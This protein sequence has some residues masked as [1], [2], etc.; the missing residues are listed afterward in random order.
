MMP[1]PDWATLDR[2]L[3][4][5]LDLEGPERETF[6]AS[7][8]DATREALVP[9]LR[10]A[11]SEDSL[12]DHPGVVLSSLR[13]NTG[14]PDNGRVIEG[15]RI[16]PYQIEALVGEG[17]MGRVFCAH[18]VDGAFDQTVAVKV[19]RS[20]LTLAGSDVAT[21]LRRERDVL[22]SLDHPGISRLLDGGET[23][24]GVPYLVTEF[25]DGAPITTWA[26]EH[27]LDV[28]ARI[29]LMI[30]VVQ[31]VDHAHRRFVVHRDLKPSNVLVTERDGVARPV[32]LDFGIA[33]LLDTTDNENSNGAPLT[34][35]GLRVL[36]PAYAAPELFDPMATVTTASDVYGLG[37]L[38]YELLTGRRPHNDTSTQIGPPTREPT[39]PSKVITTGIKGTTP[40]PDIAVRSRTLRGDLDTICLKALH[41]E[42]TRRYAS[43]SDFAA[44]LT[45]YLEGRPIEARTDS[46]AYVAGRFIRRHRAFVAAATLALVALIGG[47]GISLVLLD[48]ERTA[49]AETEAAR[50]HATEAANLLAELF[51]SASPTPDGQPVTVREVLE[52]GMERI[53]AIESDSLRAYLL[54]VTGVTYI[55][56]SFPARADSMLAASL[57]LYG[58]EASGATVSGFRLSYAATRDA[59]GDYET[60]LALGSRVYEDWKASEATSSLV[61]R[62]LAILSRAYR[63]LGQPDEALHY[64]EQAVLLA[65]EYDHRDRLPWALLELGDVLAALERYDEAIQTHR[66][67]VRAYEEVYGPE[68]D[69]TYFSRFRLGVA[70]ADV[71]RYDEA[72]TL[73]L[74]VE[75]YQTRVL[76][77]T[78]RLSYTLAHIGGFKLRQGQYE[79]AATYYESALTMGRPLLPP[80]H[81]DLDRWLS[82]LDDVRSRSSLDR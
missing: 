43:A 28:T 48:N 2:A 70:L 53:N 78:V 42:P 3:D 45:R 49:L 6:L 58:D 51:Q 36:T 16:G 39:R 8:D 59:F 44:D 35:T 41:P 57:A 26:D 63:R 17:G 69:I 64:A 56:L 80:D 55:N 27:A 50:M 11:L 25:I 72:E 46:L 18:R 1:R 31:A 61:V 77:P 24:D 9:L 47:L 81:P 71:G 4:R 76:G 12:L 10:D 67:A 13:E 22:A 79:A 32:V 21:R 20:A 52:R 33:K 14:T 5:A 29:R 15:M 34:R 40:S 75:A 66:Q 73:F 65:R 62:A 54:G 30:D 68:E 82:T 38:L 60:V 7:L 37:A 23:D 74:M 19:V